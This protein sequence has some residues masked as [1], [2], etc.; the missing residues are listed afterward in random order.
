MDETALYVWLS[1]HSLSRHAEIILSQS[2]VIFRCILE[3]P[4]K[5]DE[6]DTRLMY[7]SWNLN[8]RSATACFSWQRIMASEGMSK[9]LPWTLSRR[10][11]TEWVVYRHKG[12]YWYRTLTSRTFAESLLETHEHHLMLKHST[13][14][15]QIV[16]NFDVVRLYIFSMPDKWHAW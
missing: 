2:N 14:S 5:Q 13:T 16:N 10:P 8:C 12:K 9:P 11:Q 6:C 4:S 1:H 3:G 15:L 7:F